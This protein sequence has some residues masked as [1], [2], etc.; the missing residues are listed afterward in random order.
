MPSPGL[1][2]ARANQLL[3][4]LRVLFLLA[5][6]LAASTPSFCDGELSWKRQVDLNRDGRSEVVALKAFTQEG[7]R[8]GQ[9]L[10]L[11][12]QGRV[13]WAGPRR[14]STPQRP[15]EPLVFGGDFDRGEIELLG[16]L[17][18]D[19]SVELLGTY[20]KSDVRPT[21]FRLLRWTGTAFTHV[22]SG[23]LVQANQRPGTWVWKEGAPE[24][25]AWIER[26]VA[27]QPGRLLRV[28]V[29]DLTDGVPLA[30]QT[31]QMRA[32]PEGFV[33]AR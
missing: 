28:E 13:L 11:D 14:S 22:R 33:V 17:D 7:V 26:F 15:S 4:R 6:V 2:L 3:M 18:G 12:R 25:A 19:G 1:T 10:V 32:T 31:L 20:Q 27:L 8:L 30:P 24:A 5:L 16:D 9:L 29:T 23:D 21:R